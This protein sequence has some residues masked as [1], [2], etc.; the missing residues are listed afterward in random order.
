[1]MNELGLFAGAGGGLLASQYLV[2]CKT[3]CYVEIDSYC[4]SVLKAR[5]ADGVLDDAP[6]WD[7]I[8]TFCGEPWRGKVDL[9]S[10]GFPCTPWSVAGK[11]RGER[12]DRNLWPDTVRIIA[13]VQPRWVFLENVSGI[14]AGSHGYFGRILGDLAQV[15]YD[16]RWGV[17]SAKGC[18][19]PHLRKRLWIVGYS[20]IDRSAAMFSG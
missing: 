13:E 16:A 10:G 8:R 2:G 14:L 19:A 7:D 12:D 17:L 6:I 4:V 11:Q 9:V 5:I 15:G 20:S 3:V 1:M 18:R